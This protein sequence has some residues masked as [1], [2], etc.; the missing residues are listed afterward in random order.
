MTRIA[1]ND[2]R[3]MRCAKC[4]RPAQIKLPHMP[5]YTRSCYCDVIEQRFKRHIKP[6]GL[7]SGDVIVCHDSLSMHLLKEV[8]SL[9]LDV[10]ARRP[11]KKSIGTN[12]L[13]AERRFLDHEVADFMDHLLD[14]KTMPP[15]GF[16]PLACMSVE[17]ARAY[18][19]IRRLPTPDPGPELTLIDGMGKD[20]PSILYSTYKMLC[21]LRKIG[22]ISSSG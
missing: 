14:G 11:P 16:S 18:C 19:R 4:R 1:I 3:K 7:R 13:V 20:H 17:E 21:H 22:A 6:Y 15:Q 5:P 10:R 9:P 2:I 12:L 8:L